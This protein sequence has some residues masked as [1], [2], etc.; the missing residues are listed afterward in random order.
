MHTETLYEDINYKCR[1]SYRAS[2]WDVQKMQL[3][4]R[5]IWGDNARTDPVIVSDIFTL[6]TTLVSAEKREIL[7]YE[8]LFQNSV[9]DCTVMHQ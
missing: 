9:S 5:Y 3:H 1:F 8:N 7:M 4:N 6:L 2:L